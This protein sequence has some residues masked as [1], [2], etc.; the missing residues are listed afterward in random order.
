M[1]S[2]SYSKIKDH[3]GKSEAKDI[4]RQF[5]QDLEDAITYNSLVLYIVDARNSVLK[6]VITH[7]SG[8]AT[9][10]KSR[11]RLKNISLNE[12][13]VADVIK[14]GKTDPLNTS[15]NSKEITGKSA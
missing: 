9:S 4:H 5:V 2:S 6:P 11:A 10:G 7:I 3:P 12:G 13:I 14:K 15:L 1:R 8:K